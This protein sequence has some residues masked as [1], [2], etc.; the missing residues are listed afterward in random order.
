M[1]DAPAD[2]NDESAAACLYRAALSAHKWSATACT[3]HKGK[4]FAKRVRDELKQ[5]SSSLPPGVHVRAYEGRMDLFSLC[6]FGT[7][8]TPYELS[9]FTFDLSLPADYPASP[10]LMHFHSRGHRLSPNLYLDGT[11]CLSL[12]NTWKASLPSQR[13]D[14]AH[15]TLL[16]LFV[17]LQG[18]VIGAQEPYYLEAGYESQRGQ[19]QANLNSHLYN[20]TALLTSLA[21]LTSYATAAAAAS[22]SAMV[23][24]PFGAE[25][26][27]HVRSD[28]VQQRARELQALADAWERKKR[29]QLTQFTSTAAS[30][31]PAAAADDSSA[32]VELDE[33]ALAT[34]LARFAIHSEDALVAQSSAAPAEAAAAA[35]AASAVAPAAVPVSDG[36]ASSNAV[37]SAS[38]SSAAAAAAPAGPA[39]APVIVPYHPSLAFV[40]MLVRQMRSLIAAL[41]RAKEAPAAAA[42]GSQQDGTK[43]A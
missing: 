33:A 34:V 9:L 16:Q 25:I 15:S 43:Q 30:E 27:E 19:K 18:L 10:P 14:G 7:V 21:H 3:P 40:T 35:A 8:G 17:S 23:A 6:I 11:I 26:A 28:E 13:W 1:L 41:D 12:L 2:E 37:S 20:E 29:Q 42:T 32:S 36:A 24:A 31:T 22:S 4:V 39:G 5:L 38:S